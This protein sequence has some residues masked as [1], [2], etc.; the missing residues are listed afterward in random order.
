MDEGFFLLPK[1]P[2]ASIATMGVVQSTTYIYYKIFN[3][4]ELWRYEKWN[5]KFMQD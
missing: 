1:F 4:I 2:K 3:Y 5:V